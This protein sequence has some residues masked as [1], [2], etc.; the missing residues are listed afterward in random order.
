MMKKLIASI[1][2]LIRPIPPL[3]SP[4]PSTTAP[5]RKARMFMFGLGEV[6]KSTIIKQ[7]QV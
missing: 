6:G 2:E 5:T 7:L 3:S 4:I 1:R